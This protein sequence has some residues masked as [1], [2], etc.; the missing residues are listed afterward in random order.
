MTASVRRV[1]ILTPFTNSITVVGATTGH[2]PEV[3]AALSSGGFSNTLLRPYYQDAAVAGYLAALGDEYK[4]LYEPEGRGYPDI[5]AQGMHFQVVA[6]GQYVGT[7]GTSAS[8]PTI[9]SIVALVNDERLNAGKSTLGFMNP[10]LYSSTAVSIFNDITAGSNPGCNTDGFPAKSGWDPV[11]ISAGRSHMLLKMRV[12]RS[13]VSAASTTRG[14]PRWRVSFLECRL[15]RGLLYDSLAIHRSS[16]LNNII[17]CCLNRL[18]R[19][20]RTSTVTI[21]SAVQK[22]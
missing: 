6:N 3:A 13:L 9:A 5:S 15:S 10:L 4:G 2:S 16:T 14:S 20:S 19:I 7:S 17:L 12:D 22:P 11:R 21:P 1:F 18:Q 8:S